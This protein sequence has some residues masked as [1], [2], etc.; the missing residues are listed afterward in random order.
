MPIDIRPGQ[1]LLEAML[2]RAPQLPTEPGVYL[3][4]EQDPLSD[5]EGF[6]R[7]VLI[8]DDMGTATMAWECGSTATY[9]PDKPDVVRWNLAEIRPLTL[10]AF[11]AAWEV[12]RGK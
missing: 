11:K 6:A 10:D 8:I 1:T 9:P 3:A 2:E 4:A 5:V 12:S 7:V